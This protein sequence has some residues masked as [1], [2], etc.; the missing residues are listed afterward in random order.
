MSLETMTKLASTTVGVGGSSSVTFS[1]IPQGYTDLK[2][3]AN[4]RV[5]GSNQGEVVN[6]AFNGSSSNISARLIYAD[7]P[8]VTSITSTSNVFWVPG[9]GATSNVFG[10]SEV[11][12][13]NYSSNSNKSWSTDSALENNGGTYLVLIAGL[14]SQPA[15]ISSITLT[16]PLQPFVANSTFS[17]YGIKNARQTAGNSIKATGGNVVFDGTYVYHVF[18]S[19]GAFVPTQ[20]ILADYMVIA[21]GGA[22]G[23]ARSGGG[24]G[25]GL[26]SSIQATGGGGTLQPRISLIPGSYTVTIGAGGVADGGAVVSGNNSSIYGAGADI[27]AIGGGGGGN[28]GFGGQA[29]GAGKPGGSGGGGLQGPTAGGAPTANQGYR[30]GNGSASYLAGAGG[31]GAGAQ[32]VDVTGPTNDGTNGGIGLLLTSISVPTGAGI[33]GYFAGGGGGGYFSSAG[34]SGTAGTVGGLGGAGGGGNGSVGGAGFPG[35]ANTGGGG[36]S[37]RGNS[38]GVGDTAGGNGGSGLVVIRYKG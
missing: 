20:P 29:T 24:G 35:T 16:P 36:G 4:S 27:T 23:P 3:V 31:G 38:G 37:G 12:F 1:N 13:P 26:L 6:I 11:Y 34:L 19:S 22:G 25:G 33:N 8:N 17:L 21:G 2:I 30:G 9:S 7:S 5:A 10:N 28:S 32:G 15:A 18:N 14:W